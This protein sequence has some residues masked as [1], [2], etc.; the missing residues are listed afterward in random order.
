MAAPGA[1]TT[2]AEWATLI[3]QSVAAIAAAAAAVFAWLTARR[4]KLEHEYELRD[5][6]SEHLKQIHRLITELVEVAH[7]NPHG[8]FPIEMNLRAE[9]GVSRVPLPKC[10][11]LV[12]VRLGDLPVHNDPRRSDFDKAAEAAIAEVERAHETVWKGAIIDIIR[13]PRE[14]TADDGEATKGPTG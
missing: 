3:I 12:D 6:A 10:I 14:G 13:S 7:T 11:E 1:A 2:G 9:L 8:L 4:L 5:R